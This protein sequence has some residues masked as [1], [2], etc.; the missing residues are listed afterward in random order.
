M[1][2]ASFLCLLL[3][4]ACALAL[5]G[6]S[7][8][9]AAQRNNNTNQVEK[10]LDEQIAAAEG[11]T[12][13]DSEQGG[14]AASAGSSENNY[15]TVDF[16]LTGMNSDMVYSTVFNMLDNPESFIG[17]TVRT[18]G[19]LS[20]F[21]NDATGATYYTCLIAD[22]AACCAQGMEFVWDDG[23]HDDS[24]YPSEGSDI[25]VTGVFETYMEDDAMYCRLN[26]ADMDLVQFNIQ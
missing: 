2:P 25:E 21:R 20:V 24:E 22:A 19:T 15:D 1:K 11:N 16:D 12:S 6:C 4:L 9:G 17:K 7:G 8:S 5:T 3:A 13:H 14:T 10:T 26:H 23:T 18:K